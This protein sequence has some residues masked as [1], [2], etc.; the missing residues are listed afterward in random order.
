MR[1]PSAL[2]WSL[3]WK[4]MIHIKKVS[5][6][7]KIQPRIIFSGLTKKWAQFLNWN[8][9]VTHSWKPSKDYSNHASA[10][11][12]LENN[13]TKI[14]LKGD[15]LHIVCIF[16]A[17][18]KHYFLFVQLFV[19]DP[20]TMHND[21]GCVEIHHK[22]RLYA[23]VSKIRMLAPPNCH[24]QEPFP[25][26]FWGNSL[27]YIPIFDRSGYWMPGNS[28]P[29]GRSRKCFVYSFEA[30]INSE[31]EVRIICQSGS[32]MEK[33]CMSFSFKLIT[34]DSHTIESPG[35]AQVHASIYT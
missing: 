31:E 24:N 35:K 32:V 13:C 1:A 17:I 4:Q 34:A 8:S 27:V 18:F 29:G 33:R 9:G 22:P 21:S 3:V 26:V 19:H 16:M 28:G 5:H 2:K 23:A 11:V 20:E 14:V 30:I 15:S 12:S 10:N 6:L 25:R 7:E